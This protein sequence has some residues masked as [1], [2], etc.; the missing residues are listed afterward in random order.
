MARKTSASPLGK[1]KRLVYASAALLCLT[2]A[3]SGMALSVGNAL[4]QESPGAG[5]V[6]TEKNSQRESAKKIVVAKVNGAEITMDS[7]VKMMN[8]ISAKDKDAA[9]QEAVKQQALDR[10]ILL[11]LAFQKA[12]KDGLAADEKNVIAALENLKKNLGGEEEYKNFL[13]KEQVTEADLKAQITRSLTLELAYAREVYNKVSIPEETVKKEYE[14]EK[15]RYVTPEKMRVIDVLFLQQES[16]E[17]SQKTATEVLKKIREEKEQNPWKLSL[18]GTFIVRS[19]DIDKDRDKE[20]Y[21]AAKKMRKG[22]LSGIIRTAKTLHIIKMK[23]YSPERQMTLEEVRGNIENSL[24]V[25]AQDRRL[26]E[27]EQELRKE[28]KIEIVWP[29]LTKKKS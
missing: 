23:E 6:K 22:D 14:K 20:L 25:P 10:L 26:Q 5:E 1:T 16:D 18:D 7:L 24:R 15:A 13:A 19:Y 28:A 12:Q 11:N 21:Q 27:W 8:R 3:N 29:E 2:I 9:D 17:A 4:A